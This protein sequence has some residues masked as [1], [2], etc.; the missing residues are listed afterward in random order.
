[1]L[2]ASDYLNLILLYAEC[3]Y[4]ARAAL[5][6]YRE[7]FAPPHLN[8]LFGDQWIGRFG[9]H[10]WPPLSPDLT[11][12]LFLCGTIKDRVF[13]TECV[14]SE[15]I[16]RRLVTAFDW[17]RE[18]PGVFSRVHRNMRMR[19]RLCLQRAGGHFEHDSR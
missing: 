1:M 17:L 5:R 4:N 9:P 15:D 12:G 11:H 10:R 14:T 13:R 2:Q 7:R 8:G 16:E 3:G 18:K 19:P 6:L